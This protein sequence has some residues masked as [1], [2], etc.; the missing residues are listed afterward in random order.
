MVPGQLAN[1][2]ISNKKIH[3]SEVNTH[4]YY[5]WKEGKMTFL[6]EPLGE[7]AAKLERWY[8][9]KFTFASE[10]IKNFRY[11]GTFLKYKPLDQILEI[12]K[13]SSSIDYSIKINPEDKDEIILKNLT[14][15]TN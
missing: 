10:D 11:S 9:V 12:I 8:N 15:E 7:I 4:F 14:Y 1:Y 5:S 6:N 13:I 2:D 3:L